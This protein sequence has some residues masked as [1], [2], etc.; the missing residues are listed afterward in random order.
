MR[1]TVMLRPHRRRRLVE[2]Y[3]NGHR[4]QD[5]L[6]PGVRDKGKVRP[7]HGGFDGERDV[8]RAGVV[9]RED[10]YAVRRGR[11]LRARDRRRAGLYPLR[12]EPLLDRALELVIGRPAGGGRWRA[13]RVGTVIAVIA[14][15]RRRRDHRRAQ[16]TFRVAERTHPGARAVVRVAARLANRGYAAVSVTRSIRGS[17]RRRHLGMWEA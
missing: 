2:I 9:E 5:R 17:V 10:R 4:M 3:G 14:D 15:D 7:E 6:G 16:R 1:G 8:E 13:M 11:L 12:G